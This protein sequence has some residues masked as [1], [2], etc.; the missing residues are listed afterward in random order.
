M[1]RVLWNS[2]SRVTRIA[3][4]DGLS[5]RKERALSTNSKRSRCRRKLRFQSMSDILLEAETI[6]RARH[7]E[8]LGN[9]TPGQIFQH[10]AKSV[11]SSIRESK[12]LLP[13]WRRLIAR[14]AKPF[15]L[16][17]GL[18]S[19][20]QIERASKTAAKEFLPEN[21]IAD[22]EGLLQLQQAIAEVSQCEMHARH[23]LFGDMTPRDWEMMH[24]RHAELH[25]SFLV[26]CDT[27]PTDQ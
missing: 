26:P 14:I 4:T 27:E 9:W 22:E 3:E 7:V 13:L 24:C 10:L 18:P 17:F 25:L 23:N 6:V 1:R 21:V 16:R 5:S 15:L 12:A 8:E 11:Q 20:V 2:V 19:G